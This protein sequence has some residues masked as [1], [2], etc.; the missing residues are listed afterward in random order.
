[1]PR[2]AIDLKVRSEQLDAKVRE[3]LK[4]TPLNVEAVI[5]NESRLLVEELVDRTKPRSLSK[6]KAKVKRT[7]QRVFIAK[8]TGA[9]SMTGQAK[10]E[11]Y[12]AQHNRNYKPQLKFTLTRQVLQTAIRAAQNHAGFF[13]AGWLGK[14]NPTGARRGVP[15]YVK[16]QVVQGEVK[17]TVTPNSAKWQGW[18]TVE[19]M[20]HFPNI[21]EAELRL[22]DKAMAGR[23]YKITQNLKRITAGGAKYRVPK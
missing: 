7:Y 21:K 19:F 18:N 9:T 4:V 14:E 11:L 17:G 15:G 6:L 13:A 3:I 5:K 23:I 10:T 2:R 1:M 22:L 8:A 12:A 16:K 20:R